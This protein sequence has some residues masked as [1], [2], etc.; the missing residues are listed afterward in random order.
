MLMPKTLP[1]S[2]RALSSHLQ[3]RLKTGHQGSNCQS[4][5]LE[6]LIIIDICADG[7][8]DNL[9]PF[10]SKFSDPLAVFF[11]VA[12]GFLLLSGVQVSPG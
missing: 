4:E 12:L 11:V 9:G 3:H 5:L 6:V 8:S 2:Y 10:L 1:S 7:F